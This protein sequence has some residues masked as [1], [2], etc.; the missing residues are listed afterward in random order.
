MCLK[1]REGLLSGPLPGVGRPNWLI[2]L[3]RGMAVSDGAAVVEAQRKVAKVLGAIH[4]SLPAGGGE[5][6]TFKGLVRV[7]MGPGGGEEAR[8]ELEDEATVLCRLYAPH[9][10]SGFGDAMGAY[11]A[12]RDPVQGGVWCYTCVKPLGEVVSVPGMGGDEGFGGVMA[13]L[14]GVVGEM[15]EEGMGLGEMRSILMPLVAGGGEQDGAGG[16][17]G[18]GVEMEGLEDAMKH[19]EHV[20]GLAEGDAGGGGDGGL[21][22]LMKGIVKAEGGASAGEGGM[23]E[24]DDGLGDAKRHFEGVLGEAWGGGE[25]MGIEDMM[26]SIASGKGL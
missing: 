10:Q 21:E 14:E 11:M 4:E 13:Y 20:M 9:L 3:R 19:F 15:R 1:N 2:T 24:E 25:D 16:G 12:S 17:R 6:E 5:R 8:R 23:G 22:A 7:G 18:G 26:R